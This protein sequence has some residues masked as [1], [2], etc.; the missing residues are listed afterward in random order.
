MEN[1]HNFEH[2]NMLLC[3]WAFFKHFAWLAIYLTDIHYIK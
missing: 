3:E 1:K 2:V